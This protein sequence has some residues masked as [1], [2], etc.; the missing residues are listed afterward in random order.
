[1]DPSNPAGVKQA[2]PLYLVRDMQA[3]I[4]FYVKGLGFDVTNT[5]MVEGQIR[6]C[7]MS[8]GDAAMMFQE[9]AG[10][11]DPDKKLGLGVDL[12]L[13]CDQALAIYERAKKYGLAAEEPFVGNNMWVV[14]LRD[15]D[16]YKIT[17]ESPTDVAE[18][19]TFNQWNKPS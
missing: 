7:W 9:L 12:C 4:D 19:M 17:F 5:W 3:T 15:P 16:G 1:M 14:G 18:G 8:M 11:S 10:G 6:W 13:L 2:V